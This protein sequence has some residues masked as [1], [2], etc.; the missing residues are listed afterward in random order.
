[1]T[2]RPVYLLCFANQQDD[3]LPKLQ[4][5]SQKIND[6]L[7]HL[8]DKG[9]LEVYRE[10]SVSVD[11]LAKALVRFRD[12]IEIFHYAGHANGERL[13]F[14]GG[15]GNASGIAEL[16]SQLPKL[17]LVFLNGCATMPQVEY[18]RALGIPAII[19]TAVPIDDAQ[20]VDFAHFFYMSFAGTNSIEDAFLFALGSMRNK[21]GGMF[22]ASIYPSTE[23]LPPVQHLALPWGLFLSDDT[24]LAHRLR[25]EITTRITRPEEAAFEVNRFMVDIL[26]ELLAVKPDLAERLRER[27]GDRGLDDR[28]ALA[29]IIE[30]FPWPIGVQIRLLATRDEG[31]D[32]PSLARIRQLVSTYLMTSQFVYYCLLSQIW[33]L[34]R[35]DIHVPSPR[36]LTNILYIDPK[37][38]NVFD[39]FMGIIELTEALLEAGQSPFLVELQASAQSF[40]K[41]E[42]ISDAYQYLEALRSRVNNKD[43]QGM[44]QDRYQLCADGEYFLSD[45]LMEFAFLTKYDLITIRDIYVENYR[46]LDTRF[47]HYIGRPNAKV[48]DIMV[49]RTPRPKAFSEYANNSSVILTKDVQNIKDSLNLSPFIVD[50]NAFGSSMTEDRA[51]EQQLYIYAY[52]QGE[53]HR[54]LTILHNLYR[55]QER[56]GDQFS[57]NDGES[58]AEGSAGSGHGARRP[59]RGRG[60]A[61]SLLANR[62]EEQKNPYEILE[63]QFSLM[64]EDFLYR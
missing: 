12:R 13:D 43:E 11:S 8:H 44:E 1:M 55:A 34:K 7:S 60:G 14:V 19:A 17:K 47:N 57:T 53:N 15:G 54:Y 26:E 2:Q 56:T 42:R 4:E 38:Y 28:E 62:A 46:H 3:Y 50:K 29:L 45:F 6:T 59:R 39:Y 40:R 48:G 20:A 63:Q 25:I 31:M 16:L 51:T 21:Y 58:P 52:K 64:E 18:L 30:H 27:L 23:A 35:L 33:D 61:S 36:S 32:Q 49:G 22:T 24:V 9:V 10:E 37:S 5:E 41:G